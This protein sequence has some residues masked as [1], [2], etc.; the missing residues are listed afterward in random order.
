MVSDFIVTHPTTTWNS[1]LI[2][3]IFILFERDF[4][5]QLPLTQEP[6]EDQLM[7]PHTSD[8]CYTVKSGY[9]L[10]KQ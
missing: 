2:D 8:G 7:W 3:N 1:A 5:K 6:M 9:Y 10:L 4:I